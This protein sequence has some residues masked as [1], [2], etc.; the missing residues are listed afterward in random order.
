MVPTSRGA[1][2]KLDAE[3][4]L[5]YL[6]DAG[7]YLQ[8]CIFSNFQTILCNCVT[9]D[10]MQQEYTPYGPPPSF[11]RPI[12]PGDPPTPYVDSSQVN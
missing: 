5:H 3:P 12:T 1:D 10:F 2:S 8:V 6:D 7:N 11:P 4:A 9:N